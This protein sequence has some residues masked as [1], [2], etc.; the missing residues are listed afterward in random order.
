MEERA[1]Q[2]ADRRVPAYSWYALGLLVIVYL[3]N[4][5]DRQILSILANDI[6]ADLGL[7]DAQLGFL[8]GTAFAIFYALFGIPLGR[9]ADGWN[10]TRLLAAGL[11]LWSLMT[12]LS[13]LARNGATLAAA[14]VGVGIGEATANPCAYSL[15]ADWFPQRV[16]ATALAIYSSGLFVGSGLSL[17][18]GGLIVQSWNAA[19]PEGAPLGLAGWQAAFVAVGAPGLVLALWVLSLREPTRGAF[20]GGASQVDP[21]PWRNLAD[22][23]AQIVPP[24]TLIGAARRGAR[25]LTTNLA[26][27]AALALAAWWLGELSGNLPQFAFVAVAWYAVVSWAAHLRATDPQAFEMTWRNPAFAGVVLAYAIV[28]YLGYTVSYWAAPYAE[29]TFAFDK[30]E[31][32]WLI[33]APAALGGFLGVI[34]GGWL[35]DRLHRR[36]P[37]GRLMVMAI[38]LLAPIPIVVIGY[39]TADPTVFLVCAFL[40]QMVTSSALGASAAASQALVLP[41]MRGI[42]AAI[43]LLGTT[44]IGLAF[45]PFTAGFVSEATG[46]LATGVIGNLLAI[47]LGLAALALGLRHYRAALAAQ[48]AALRS[49]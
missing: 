41:R 8:Y 2:Q 48:A 46:S 42:A 24:F 31:L 20:E 21:H 23:L 13:G 16:R 10:R 49:A 33:G 34:A 4:F 44:L 15:I 30:V 45:G 19:W 17:L 43:F 3:L 27:A 25:A 14:R 28:C 38:G 37:A 12:A 26:A 32:G 22:S 36:H 35:A 40:V 18:V 6:K 29:R 7:D 9:L 11:A 5:V 39:S 1:E 47:P